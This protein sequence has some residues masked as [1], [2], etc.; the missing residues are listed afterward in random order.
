MAEDLKMTFPCVGGPFT[1][2]GSRRLLCDPANQRQLQAA[3]V[4]LRQTPRKLLSIKEA[5]GDRVAGKLSLVPRSSTTSR[6][7]SSHVSV[8]ISLRG[9][10]PKSM[11]PHPTND[12]ERILS[13]QLTRGPGVWVRLRF[14][15]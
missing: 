13:K 4:Q 8:D 3:V 12:A 2:I 14:S 11:I 7:P 9:P 6:G 15:F 10:P 5:N 1:A